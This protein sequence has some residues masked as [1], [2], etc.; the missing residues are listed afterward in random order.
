LQ[1]KLKKAEKFSHLE[2][3]FL[4]VFEGIMKKK[5]RKKKRKKVTYLEQYLSPATTNNK[6]FL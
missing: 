4:R 2:T 3:Y 1:N 6:S 5:K